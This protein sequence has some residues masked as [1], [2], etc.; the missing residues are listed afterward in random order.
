[1][2]PKGDRTL[3]E[4]RRAEST[5]MGHWGSCRLNHQPKSIHR[6][7]LG[8]HAHMLQ[9]CSLILMLVPNIWNR[10]YPKSYCLFLEYDLIAELPCL[11]SVGKAISSLTET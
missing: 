8:L 2:G 9:V 3:Q 11:T 6:L 4:D 1:V 5:N 7:D 10:G